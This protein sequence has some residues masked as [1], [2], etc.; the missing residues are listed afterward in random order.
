MKNKRIK[1][2]LLFSFLI[3]LS[4]LGI[5]SL[6]SIFHD[7]TG[8]ECKICL[9]VD[10]NLIL[11]EFLITCLLSFSISYHIIIKIYDKNNKYNNF[12]NLNKTIECDYKNSPTVLVNFYTKYHIRLRY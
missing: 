11:I 12:N 10:I 2:I 7:C 6:L 9:L 8:N 1:K 3:L 4:L 5:F